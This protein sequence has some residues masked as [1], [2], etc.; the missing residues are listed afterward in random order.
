MHGNYETPVFLF[1][2][3][4]WPVV[5]LAGLSDDEDDNDGG[6]GGGVTPIWQPQPYKLN[7]IGY[8]ISGISSTA[9]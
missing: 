4:T 9:A 5:Q 1:S 3:S 2:W 7:D 6:G 8:S